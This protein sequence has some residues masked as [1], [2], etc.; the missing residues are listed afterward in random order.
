YSGLQ[1][2]ARAA[3]R[4]GGFVVLGKRETGLQAHEVAQLQ[5]EQEC[6]AVPGYHQALDILASAVGQVDGVDLF[7]V[8]LTHLPKE[9][10]DLVMLVHWP[11]LQSTAPGPC[12]PRPATSSSQA[13]R[14]VALPELVAS[15]TLCTSQIR[16]RA[17][18]SGS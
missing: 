15:G 3:C 8:P 10:P 13:I 5:H 17:V 4:P 1:R 12:S 11:A 16:S 7:L 6:V 9:F 2:A 14:A 18:T